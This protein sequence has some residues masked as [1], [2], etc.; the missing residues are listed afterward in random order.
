MSLFL[1]TH[2]S[3]LGSV[4]LCVLHSDNNSGFLFSISPEKKENN[5]AKNFL[6]LCFFADVAAPPLNSRGFPEKLKNT[7][8]FSSLS[9]SPSLFIAGKKLHTSFYRN[10][11]LASSRNAFTF[12]VRESKIK[13][14]GS[15]VRP[16]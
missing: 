13:K 11:W 8:F 6:L 4:L 5:K 15:S 3:N 1:L 12:R 2:L 9:F 10:D 16:K 7:V 14:K